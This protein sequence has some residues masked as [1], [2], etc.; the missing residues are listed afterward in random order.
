MKTEKLFHLKGSLEGVKPASVIAEESLS[1]LSQGLEI[2]KKGC[3]TIK[4]PSKTIQE[5]GKLDPIRQH[6][7]KM[8]LYLAMQHATEINLIPQE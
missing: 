7:I 8:V 5:I 4:I 6:R 3:M 2:V 1:Q